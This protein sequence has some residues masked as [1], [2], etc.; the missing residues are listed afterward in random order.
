MSPNYTQAREAGKDLL[1]VG[2]TRGGEVHDV[3]AL[4][5]EERLCLLR[6]RRH[7]VAHQPIHRHLRRQPDDGNVQLKSTQS[8]SMT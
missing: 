8:E 4:G 3:P 5:Q 7:D 2:A 1:A 6:G